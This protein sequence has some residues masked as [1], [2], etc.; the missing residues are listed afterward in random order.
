ME[1]LQDEVRDACGYAH[2]MESLAADI[3]DNYDCDSDAHRYLNGCG[4]RCC[5]ATKILEGT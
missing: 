2:D 5:E 1:R 3:R 4:C